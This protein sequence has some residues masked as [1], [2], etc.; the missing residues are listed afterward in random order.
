MFKY[1]SIM[2]AA[3][4]VFCGCEPA[5]VTDPI[6]TMYRVTITSHTEEFSWGVVGLETAIPLLESRDID[7][8]RGMAIDKAYFSIERE[9]VNSTEPYVVSLG[10]D[11]QQNLL[12]SDS[13]DVSED[14]FTEISY[15]RLNISCSDPVWRVYSEHNIYVHVEILLYVF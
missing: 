15:E 1:F 6:P 14:E 4:I 8:S 5:N 12:F 3:I 2:L 7:Y 11:S 9:D 10:L 13:L